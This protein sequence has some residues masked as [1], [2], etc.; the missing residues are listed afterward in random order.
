MRQRCREIGKKRALRFRSSKIDTED[1][2][3]CR[4]SCDSAGG[5]VFRKL[6]AD[7]GEQALCDRRLRIGEDRPDLAFLH[8]APRIDD[9]D[10]IGNAAHHFHLVGNQKD[11]QTK[12]DG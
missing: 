11:G 1:Q 10:A 9:G 8:D 5:D 4:R 7:A 3:P 6:R 2:P 12:L